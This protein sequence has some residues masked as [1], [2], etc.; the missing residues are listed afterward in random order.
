MATNKQDVEKSE[1]RKVIEMLMN[2][3]VKLRD[4]NEE[5]ETRVTALRREKQAAQDVKEENYL[6]AEILSLKE[7][8]SANY[9]QI[10][11]NNSQ[12]IEKEKQITTI[13]KNQG[14]ITAPPIGYIFRQIIY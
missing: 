6:D 13:I 11:S 3:I 10:D 5:Y 4:A 8:I 7:R 9:R 2:E 14:K 12:I 1:L